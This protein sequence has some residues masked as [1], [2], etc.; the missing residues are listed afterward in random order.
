MCLGMNLAKL[1]VRAL[2]AALTRK[3]T[4]FHIEDSRSIFK[5]NAIIHLMIELMLRPTSCC[6]AVSPRPG[7]PSCSPGACLA[8]RPTYGSLLASL[9]FATEGAGAAP[10]TDHRAAATT[11]L[12][13][14]VRIAISGPVS[15][16]G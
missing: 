12:S 1:E 16:V 14:S 13:C 9:A 11:S 6:R 4:R 3:V 7:S 8:I 2:F 15:T 10:M 5:R